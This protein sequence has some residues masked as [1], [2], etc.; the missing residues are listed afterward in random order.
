MRNSRVLVAIA[1]M[2]IAVTACGSE[3]GGDGATGTTAP[4]ATATT[5]APGTN[6]PTPTTAG[7]DGST[8]GLSAACLGA[9]QAMSAA[10]AAYAQGFSGSAPGT[11][12]VAEQL[13]VMA[14]AAPTEIKDDL[15]VVAREI[16]AFYEVIGEINLVPGVTPTPEQIEKLNAAAESVDQDALDEATDNL[17]AWFAENCGD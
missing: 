7:T 3:D 9:T 14:A 15:E 6:P 1:V 5:G 16:G 17:D 10:L 8:G 12:D 11:E 2:S 4:A 13:R